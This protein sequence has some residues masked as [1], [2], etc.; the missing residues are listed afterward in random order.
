MRNQQQQNHS[1]QKIYGSPDQLF[2]GLLKNRCINFV[3]ST[4]KIVAIKLAV[5]IPGI[6]P[7]GSVDP[8]ADR[9]AIILVGSTVTQVVLMTKNKITIN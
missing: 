4:A 5:K 7:A 9:I 2:P 3:N 8:A 1:L 6:T